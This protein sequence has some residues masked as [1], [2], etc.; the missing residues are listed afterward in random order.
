VLVSV[1]YSNVQV[2][3]V[4]SNVTATSSNSDIGTS[5]SRTFFTL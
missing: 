3:V 5:Y 2:Q 1:T 4:G